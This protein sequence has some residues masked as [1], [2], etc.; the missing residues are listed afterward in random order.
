MHPIEQRRRLSQ[1]GRGGESV[2]CAGT[3]V[4]GVVALM[5]EANPS[6][7][8]RDVH[9]ILALSASHTGSG[10]ASGPVNQEIDGWHVART[11]TWNGGGMA[12]SADY[13]FGTVNALAAV[14]LAEVWGLMNGPAQ[15]VPIRFG[16][17]G[18]SFFRQIRRRQGQGQ[19]IRQQPAQ[20]P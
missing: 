4:S 17:F 20:Q 3:L 19:T 5:L 11:G 15:A 18:R 10:L 2:T 16:Y 13:G 7:G 14:S 6:L 12:H 1:V 9:N 8:W